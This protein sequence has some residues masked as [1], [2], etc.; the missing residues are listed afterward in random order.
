MARAERAGRGLESDDNSER[1]DRAARN[2]G[3][4]RRK[5]SQAKRRGEK[6]WQRVLE[7]AVVK[8]GL[9]RHASAADASALQLYFAHRTNIHHHALGTVVLGAV[10]ELDSAMQERDE[11]AQRSRIYAIMAGLITLLDQMQH[12]DGQ[13]ALAEKASLLAPAPVA[14]QP[15]QPGYVPPPADAKAFA[16]LVEEDVVRAAGAAIRKQ[17]K[18]DKT[19]AEALQARLAQ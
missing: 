6:R 17:V 18:L 5:Q 19:A 1:G 10:M 12:D 9:V 4:L 13:L 16:P 3:S 15:S 7:K 2:T 8:A 11:S 14:Y